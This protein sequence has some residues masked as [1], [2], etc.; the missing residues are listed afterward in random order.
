MLLPK[1]TTLEYTAWF[2][3]S[4]NNPAN[5]DPSQTVRWGDQS[6]EEMNIGFTE[7]AIKAT[8]DPEVALLHG[9]TR[10]APQR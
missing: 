5:P 6:W 9:T 7:I 4:S 10:P 1:G 8:A 2:D 3:N